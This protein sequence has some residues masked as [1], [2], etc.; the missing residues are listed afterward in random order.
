MLRG[1]DGVVQIDPD[2]SPEDVLRASLY[3][4]LAG[5]LRA[6]P[7]QETLNRLKVMQGDQSMLGKAIG[8]LARLADKSTAGSVDQEYHALFIGID[9]GEVRPYG[10][11][12]M[13]DFLH[14]GPLE[15]LRSDMSRAG[16]GMRSEV[17]EPE[18]HIAALCEMMAGMILGDFGTPVSLHEQRSFFKAHMSAW[19]GSFFSDL[20]VARSSVFYAAVGT[21]GAAFMTIEEKAFKMLWVEKAPDFIP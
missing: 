6:P 5:L 3:R 12:Y 14:E 18:D 15:R 8:T 2:I 1:V 9:R 16:I 20:E 11:A 21:I 17:S 7:D 10:S 19:A 13:T 4:M